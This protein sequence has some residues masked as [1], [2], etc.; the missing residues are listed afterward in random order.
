MVSRKMRGPEQRSGLNGMLVAQTR[1]KLI[2]TRFDMDLQNEECL[3]VK[4]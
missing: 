1:L 2:A 4:V 3:C